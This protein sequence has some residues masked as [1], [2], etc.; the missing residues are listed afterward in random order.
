MVLSK[1][2]MNDVARNLLA[3][4]CTKSVV[5]LNKGDSQ[6]TWKSLNT[7]SQKIHISTKVIGICEA[8]ISSYQF[9]VYTGQQY[10]KVSARAYT[11]IEQVS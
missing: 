11:I 1:M 3:V 8:V 10:I 7:K 5:G 2:V 4:Y 6:V 9:V